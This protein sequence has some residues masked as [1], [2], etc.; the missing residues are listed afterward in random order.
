[1][2]LLWKGQRERRDATYPQTW[3]KEW[4]KLDR[5]T[6]IPPGL[7]KILKSPGAIIRNGC[8]ALCPNQ[9]KKDRIRMKGQELRDAS[10]GD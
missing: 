9:S 7:A 2:P 6:L 10:T 1:M 3:E 5:R 8:D 4:E